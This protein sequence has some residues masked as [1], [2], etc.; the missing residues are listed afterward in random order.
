M[1]IANKKIIADYNRHH[2]FLLTLWEFLKGKQRQRVPVLLCIF[3]YFYKDVAKQIRI[4][5]IMISVCVQMFWATRA[6]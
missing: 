1:L 5:R 3:D 4:R 6:V 2:L